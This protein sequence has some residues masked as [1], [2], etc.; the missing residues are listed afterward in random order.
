M[1]MPAAVPRP[2][3]LLYDTRGLIR[4][5]ATISLPLL[6]PARTEM[7]YD[8]DN[9]LRFAYLTTLVFYRYRTWDIVTLAC[10]WYR[11]LDLLRHM[12]Y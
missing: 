5:P 3:R 10:G 4:Y 12:F 6:K 7:S 2:R 9:V 8:D 1:F 11:V